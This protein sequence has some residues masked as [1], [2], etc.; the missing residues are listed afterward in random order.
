M[1]SLINLTFLQGRNLRFCPDF[2]YPSQTAFAACFADISNV[3][4]T[5]FAKLT[6]IAS[7]H[8]NMKRD[9]ASRLLFPLC[10]M[11]ALT[12]TSCNKTAKDQPSRHRFIHNNDGSDALLNRWF[13]G[14]P[15]HKADIDRY[16]D[17]VAE[18]SKGR[19]QVTTFMMCS[20]SDFI[21]YPSSKYGR[22]FGDDKN[23][24][25][26]YADSATKKVWQLGGQSVRNLEA[27]GT[28]VIKASLER[29]K[30]H[31]MEAFITY[32]VNDLHFA[33]SSSGN[34]ATFPDFWI[35]HPEYWTGDSTQG[36][37]SAQALDFSY[38][39]VRQHKLNLIKEQ[40][41]KYDMIDGYELDF[42]RFI[43]LFKSGEGKEK[44]PLITDMVREVK[45]TIDSLSEVRGHKILLAV[46]V[47]VTVEGALEKG[48]DVKQWAKEGLIDFITI[49]VHWRGDT[50]IPVAKF[51][52]DFGYDDIPL[53]ASIDDG[54]YLPREFYS[55]GMYRGMASHIL[56]QGADGVY[57]FNYYFGEISDRKIAG[58]PLLEEGGQVTRARTPELLNELG[59]L[60]TLKGRNKIYCMSDGV[61]DAY[62]ALGIAPLPAA[63]SNGRETVLPLFIADDTQEIVPQEMIL[64]LRTDRPAKFWLEVNGVEVTE[65]KPE[66]VKLYNR[67]RGMR[68]GEQM[69]AFILPAG[70]IRKGDN[71][72][73]MVD[74][75][76]DNYFIVQRVEVALKYGDVETN[77]YF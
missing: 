47:P 23:G 37:H 18:T 40:L 7:K 68:D 32:R 41:E 14:H 15:A 16:V 72:I 76:L 26:P 54:G 11:L 13:G 66:Y 51:R 67:D 62:R 61:T 55:D 50:G 5:L 73:R 58:I 12:V 48:L 57:L 9:F 69:Y 19:T 43:V 35:E 34:P 46:R 36:W 38:P 20:G 77:G 45:R 70:S 74:K 21:Y 17:M 75:T 28:D 42:M 10:G 6:P 33:D 59:S 64:F 25:M 2:L 49:G 56:G 39:E 29:A 24:T 8:L 52:K 44:A 1:I 31:G 22:Y 53:Y 60:E 27:E 4:L 71:M 63:V 30:M 3:L 65:Q